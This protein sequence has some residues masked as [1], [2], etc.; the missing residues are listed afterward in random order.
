MK[1]ETEQS[2]AYSGTQREREEAEWD[3]SPLHH[4]F[5]LL[6]FNYATHEITS[7]SEL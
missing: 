1:V 3:L 4:R 5:L 6:E 2:W 7:V